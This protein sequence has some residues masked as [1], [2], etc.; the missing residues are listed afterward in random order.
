VALDPNFAAA[1]ANMPYMYVLLASAAPDVAGAHEYKRLA[2]SMAR[3][4]IRLDPLLPE[5]HTALGMASDIGLR[6]LTTA[7]REFRRAIALGGSPR[8]HEH[9]ANVLSLTG[10]EAEAL[11][12]TMRSVKEDPLSATAR[13]ELGRA[14]CINRQYDE[15]LAELARVAHVRPPLLRVAG[16]VAI[17]YGLQGKWRE[18]ATQLRDRRRSRL[19]PLLGYALARAGDT[20]EAKTIRDELLVRWRTHQRG[21]FDLAVVAAG[22]GDFDEAFEWLD[23]SVDD[24]TL[25]GVVLYPMFRELRGDPRFGKFLAR[26]GVQK[27]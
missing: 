10:R 24:L 14:L 25:N 18:A 4:A 3:T 17:C 22:L 9:L 13:A 19:A 11:A 7:E 2:D 6:D 23:R 26:L 12:E 15:G 27:R 21:A 20:A 16:Y 8:V 5:A 1:Y